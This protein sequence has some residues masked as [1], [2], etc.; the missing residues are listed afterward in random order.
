MK[1]HAFRNRVGGTIE[2]F[3]SEME[4][5]LQRMFGD[6]HPN[7]EGSV[8][9]PQVDV[10]ETERE[11]LV[12]V[13]LP[14]V[15]TK[16]IDISISGGML[17]LKGERKEEREEAKGGYQRCERFMGTFYRELPI[18]SSVDPDQITAETAKGVVSIHLPK[19]PELKPKK[20]AV[21]ENK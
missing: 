5:L 19:K 21:Q 6:G 20:I 13:D 11:F 14:G 17:M 7:K 8:W 18:P 2:R 10:S 12:K 4:D 15:E 16:D 1:G 3:Q 9:V